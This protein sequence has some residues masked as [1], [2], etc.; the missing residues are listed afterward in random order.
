MI[1]T[2]S[3][4]SSLLRTLVLFLSSLV[5]VGSLP[6]AVVLPSAYDLTLGEGLVAP[7]G[8]HSATPVFSWKLPSDTKRQSAYQLELHSDTGVWDSGWVGSDQSV[9]VRYGGKPLQSRQQAR[10][11]VRYRNE[12]G[13]SSAWSDWGRFEMGLLSNSDWSAR[14]IR[15]AGER[16]KD[17][18]SVGWLRRGFTLNKPIAKARLYATAKGLFELHLNGGRVGKDH[19]ANGWTS[20]HKRLDTLTYDVT[21]QVQQGTNSLV[22][23]LG[24]GWYAGRL[25]FET[26]VRGPYGQDPELLVQLEI[27]H[28]DGSRLV[29]ASG[30]EWEGTFEGPILSSSIYDGEHYDARKALTGWRP[31]ICSAELGAARLTPKPFP[32]IRASR[33]LL[34][35]RITEPTPGRFIFD[36]GQNMVGWARLK[37]P[38]RENETVTVRFAEMLQKDGSLY[39]ENYRSAKSTDSYT[40]ANTGIAEWEPHFTFHGFRYVELSGIP[41]GVNPQLDWVTGVV[42]HSDLRPL[43]RFE[44]SH[45]K[46][47]QLQSNI[48]WGWRG[49]SLDIPTDCPQRDERAGWTGDA[50]VF[51]ATSLFNTDAL[52]FWKSWLGAMRDDQNPDG[53]IPDFVPSAGLNWRN[54]SPG[55]MDAAIHIP[56][57]LYVRTG[58]LGVLEDN[59]A[60][61]RSVLAWYRSQSREGLLPEI[62]GFG[63]WLQPFP[64]L[65]GEPGN[66]MGS[67]HGD[68]PSPLL[69]SAYYARSAQLLSKIALALGHE[70]DASTFGEEARKVAAAFCAEY[71]DRDYKR[72]G[73]LETQTAYVLALAFDLVPDSGRARVAEH[74]ARL[75]REA[76]GHL[77]TG[78]LGTRDL[79]PVLDATGHQDLACELLFRESY[80]SWFYS[81]NQGAT[82]LWERW[83]SYSHEAGFG[84]AGMNSFNHYAY[85]AVGQWM[86]ERLAGLSPDQASPGYKHFYLRPLPAPQLNSARAELETPYGKAVSAWRRE[87]AGLI[88]EVVVPPNTQATLQFPGKVRPDAKLEAGTHRFELSHPAGGRHF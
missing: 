30:P 79:I 19:F 10:W 81:I 54:R 28:T 9:F 50:L 53:V 4:M 41:N 59:Y 31:V 75:V 32:P 40:A 35:Q 84:D 55:W 70:E 74:L 48:V 58:N 8:F 68:T 37:I 47:N 3:P 20:Y 23:T 62:Q 52:A 22:A 7:L 63:D 61:M 24:T 57:D 45:A 77:R 16:A 6:G 26:K 85:G 88:L 13:A 64:Q 12:A 25:P 51:C 49:N 80:P 72:K 11:R 29:I 33:T 18:E 67:L 73:G 34:P 66:W 56:W 21:G 87:G 60:M 38:V 76:G 86:Y 42:L 17:T 14:W 15:P 2:H 43:G 82:T 65:K 44:S 71:F 36:L 27:E 46:L 78:F 39:T 5:L 69:G 83:N 1:S